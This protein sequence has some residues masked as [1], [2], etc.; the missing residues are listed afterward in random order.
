MI[1]NYDKKC[2]KKSKNCKIRKKTENFE[3]PYKNLEKY[4]L[5]SKFR[6]STEKSV[7]LATLI[8]MT[9]MFLP[10]TSWYLRFAWATAPHPRNPITQLLQ[11]SPC[12]TVPHFVLVDCVRSC[13]IKITNNLS[14]SFFLLSVTDFHAQKHADAAS[15]T[16]R[17]RS[18]RG[19]Q[20]VRQQRGFRNKQ[21]AS[22]S[23]V[24]EIV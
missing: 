14:I 21:A 24:L 23:T 16:R 11:T 5:F 13:T 2:W 8:W 9:S 22:V 19:Q 4:G 6:T 15:T 7:M 3:T 17:W 18:Q 10:S 20:L 1:S 12:R